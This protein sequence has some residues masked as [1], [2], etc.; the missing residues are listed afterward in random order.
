MR[1]TWFQSLGWDDPLEKGKATHSSI[2]AWWIPWTIKVY[3]V[4]KSRTWLSDFHFQ[5]TVW[6]EGRTWEGEYSEMKLIGSQEAQVSWSQSRTGREGYIESVLGGFYVTKGGI[7]FSG[8]FNI[9]LGLN[10]S[11]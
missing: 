8:S 3:G 4:A 11:T 5:V 7:F 2:L 6:L 9:A 1:K 10:I